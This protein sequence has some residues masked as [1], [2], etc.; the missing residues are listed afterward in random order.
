MIKNIALGTD[1][2]PLYERVSPDDS[3]AMVLTVYFLNYSGST[4]TI[5]IYL[6]EVGNSTA[7]NSNMVVK[8]EPIEAGQ[9]F[10]FDAAEK[11]LLKGHTAPASRNK[12]SA[13]AS[14]GSAVTA[15]VS[16]SEL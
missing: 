3:E 9:T 16:V 5:T 6:K 11:L 12:L 10:E 13:K 2:T 15:T 14:S 8:E 1:E 4:V 7:N